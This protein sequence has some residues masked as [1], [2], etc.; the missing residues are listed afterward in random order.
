MIVF[1]YHYFSTR[2][3]GTGDCFINCISA[4]SVALKFNRLFRS[5][6]FIPHF[7]FYIPHFSFL[8]PHSSLLIP[9]SS[10][11]TPHSSLLTYSSSL[12]T[13]HSSLF[14]PHST[15]LTSHFSFLIPH[16]SLL[17]SLFTLIFYLLSIL[18]RQHGHK[19]KRFKRFFLNGSVGHFGQTQHPLLRTLV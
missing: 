19:R 7:T 12:L 9:H 13:S 3:V 1:V 2:Y 17:T 14:I 11:L 6:L 15:F 18:P 5:L 10:L 16:S 4:L 8:T